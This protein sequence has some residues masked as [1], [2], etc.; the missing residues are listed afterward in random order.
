MGVRVRVW[1]CG[2]VRKVTDGVVYWLA[3]ATIQEFHTG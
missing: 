3:A 1:K 2:E